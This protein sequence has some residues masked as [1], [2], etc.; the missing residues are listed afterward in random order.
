M[1][2]NLVATV[3]LLL[4][5][6]AASA[7]PTKRLM[8][9]DFKNVLK[10]A[11]YDFLEKSITDAV[12]KRLQENFVYSEVE[13]KDWLGVAKDH[14]IIEEDLYTYTA[15]MN[16]GLNAQPDVAIF[17]GFVI[18]T[19][20]DSAQQEITARVRILDLSQRKEI[21][22]FEVKSIVDSSIFKTIDKI[23]ERIVKEASA[24]L[25][26]KD[27]WDQGDI[28]DMTRKLNQ[29]SLRSS[30]SPA[31]IG[32]QSRSVSNE[33][34]HSAADF[35]N[36]FGFSA[37]FQRFGI[38][39]E[40]LGFFISG[41]VRLAAD[42]FAYA[43]NGSVVPASLLGFGGVAGIS[44][45]QSLGQRLYLQPLIGAGVQ[46]D[47]IRFTYDNKS[48]IV[49]SNGGQILSQ[50]ELTAF[51]PVGVAGVRFGYKITDWLFLEIGMHYAAAFYIQGLGQQLNAELGAG[52]RL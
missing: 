19:R 16:L 5:S 26:S 34:R 39:R 48:V 45:R 27:A 20:K 12:R 7:V 49:S 33:S 32:D 15:A 9:L 29:L 43:L 23:V 36:Q 47:L 22:D 40:Q 11:D 35:K 3:I 51:A 10:K 41:S 50:S 1:R 25:P 13:K 31:T 38:W 52:F 30:Y 24:V 18:E 2:R 17:G 46:Y 4:V 37:D 14:Y 42:Q 21:A 8:L 44:W 6:A 28:P